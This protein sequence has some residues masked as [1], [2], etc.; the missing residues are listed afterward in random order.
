MCGSISADGAVQ[1]QNL[2]S[3]QV[4]SCARLTA[5]HRFASLRVPSLICPRTMSVLDM[6]SSLLAPVAKWMCNPTVEG[7]AAEAGMKG[8]KGKSELSA[9]CSNT[10]FPDFLNLF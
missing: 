2:I 6:L 10:R 1:S 5:S 7:P 3:C 8:G 9:L 4:P